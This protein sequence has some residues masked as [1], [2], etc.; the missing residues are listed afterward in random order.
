MS[1]VYEGPCHLG[2]NAIFYSCTQFI[3]S[4]LGCLNGFLYTL[5]PQFDGK[6]SS[7]LALKVLFFR[8]ENG[9]EWVYAVESVYKKN[10]SH[11]AQTLRQ[12][13]L[14][15]CIPHHGNLYGCESCPS[16]KLSLHALLSTAAHI[17]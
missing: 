12:P 16:L 2:I 13:A 8:S 1:T 15:V 14:I 11:K 3:M 17:N 4:S 9:V 6:T 10:I 5:M 7:Y